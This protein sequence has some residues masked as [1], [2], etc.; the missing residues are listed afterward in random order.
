MMRS[1]RNIKKWYEILLA[2][3]DNWRPAAD[4]IVERNYSAAEL[5]VPAAEFGSGSTILDVAFYFQSPNLEG[6]RRQL[7]MF[8]ILHMCVNTQ[9]ASGGANFSAIDFLLVPRERLREFVCLTAAGRLPFA[10]PNIPELCMVQ[11]GRSFQKS[12]RKELRTA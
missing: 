1:R 3:E 4:D 8:D 7:R 2:I 12:F 10:D 5:C 6:M 11:L 9:Q